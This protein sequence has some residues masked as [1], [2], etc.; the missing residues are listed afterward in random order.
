MGTKG[1]R[2]TGTR[3]AGISVGT[4]LCL[5]TTVIP[6]SSPTERP[7]AVT[8]EGITAPLKAEGP[9]SGEAGRLAQDQSW[10]I[11]RPGLGPRAPRPP[12]RGRVPCKRPTSLSGPVRPGEKQQHRGSEGPQRVRMLSPPAHPQLGLLAP[13]C[14][15]PHAYEWPSGLVLMFLLFRTVG[16][17]MTSELDGDQQGRQDTRWDSDPM[18]VFF[19]SWV[20]LLCSGHL[21]SARHR[22]EG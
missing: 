22:A 1:P 16:P 7:H 8:S 21:P 10:L 2:W 13:P 20:Q 14:R 12:A 9:S 19:S 3:G 4:G 17:P 6:K 18:V 11:P 15:R 5:R